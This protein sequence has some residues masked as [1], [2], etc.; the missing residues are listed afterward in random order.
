MALLQVTY[1][2]RVISRCCDI[3]WSPRSSDLTPL[4]LFCEAT[5]K[6]MFKPSILKHLKTNIRQF[7]AEIPPNMCQKVIENYIKR[8][9]VWNTSRGGRLNDVVFQT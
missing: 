6:T 3:N 7:M 2:G 4:D 1:P 5:R 8:I 9:N